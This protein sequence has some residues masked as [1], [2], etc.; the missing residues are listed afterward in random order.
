MSGKPGNTGNSSFNA[1][2]RFQMIITAFEYSISLNINIL[3]LIINN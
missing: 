2:K 1:V 3:A